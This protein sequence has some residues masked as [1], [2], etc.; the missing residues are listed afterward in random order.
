M[1]INVSTKKEALQVIFSKVRR[2]YY[3]PDYT[4]AFGEQTGGIELPVL[5]GGV[6]FNT[7]DPQKNDVRL[8]DD[9]IWLGNVSQGDSDISLQIS[10]V[11]KTANELFLE[12]N[13]SPI[14]GSFENHNY[15]LQGFSLAPKKV[16]GALLLTS[17]DLDTI[18]YLP[19][20]EMYAS[21]N[22]EGGDD[23]TGYYNVAVT[24][25]TDAAGNAIY[26]PNVDAAADSSSSE[27]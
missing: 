24:P 11:A 19:H 16:T 8:T 27:G 9:T 10:S 4:K 22:G 21:F 1:A 14:T 12:K 6:T 23:S 25:L 7:G 26:L 13:G 3:F 20:I 15:T 2:A 17:P 18:V 5:D